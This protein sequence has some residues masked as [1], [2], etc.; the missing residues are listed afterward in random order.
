[1][2]PSSDAARLERLPPFAWL[3][4]VIVCLTVIY[5]VVQVLFVRP[6]LWPAGAGA[7]IAGDPAAHLPL[8][9][10][11]PDVRSEFGSS[12]V[13]AHVAPGSPAAAQG[14]TDGDRVLSVK[15]IGEYAPIR[16]GPLETGHERLAAWREFYRLSVSGTVE[17][18]IQTAN[19]PPKSVTLARPAIWNSD[20]TGWARRHLGMV[21]QTCVF[22]GAALLLL[23]MRSYDVTAGL[24]VLALAFSAVGGGGPL[25][26]AERSLGLPGTLLTLFSWLASPLAFPSI[27]LAIF[28]FPKRS[29]LLDRFPSL[30]AVP[31]LAALPLLGPALATALYIA[32]VNAA[33]P[34]AVWDATHP[35]LYFAA[36]ACALSINLLAVVEGSYRYRVNHN[37][38]E[39]RRIRMA[40]YTTVPGFLAYAV[41]DGIPIVAS[42]FGGD[43][44][45]YS[46][47]LTV[48]LDVLVLLPA[49]GLVYSVGVQ[50]VLGP[51]VVLRR[52]LQYALANR[53]LTVLTV[54]PALALTLSLVRERDRTLAQIA[55][56]SSALY[57][58]LIV[59]SVATFKYRERARL[60]LDQRF[61]REEYDARK[62]LLSL[63]SRVR[64]ETDPADLATMVI[65][66]LDEALHPLMSAILVS[67]IEDARLAPVTVL[68]GSAESLPLEGG[69]VSML[70]WSD[71]PLEIDLGD[72]RSP[73]RRL[74]PEEREWLECTGAV[75]LVPVVG[76]DRT[77]IAVIALGERR[78]EEAYTAE[79]RQL[80]A[81][82]AAQMGLGF[83]VARL[84]RRGGGP[85]DTD[86]TRIVTAVLE[87]MRECPN[88]GR[89]EEHSVRTCPND[90]TEMRTVPSVPR[91]IDNKYRI[92]QLLGRGGM[93]AVY[94][95]RDM[96]LDRLVALKVVRA[97]LLGDPEARR[98]FRREAQI[99]AR[100]QHPSIVA[101]FDYGT[102]AD[103]GAYLVM[104]LVR[105][106]DL[107][108][109]LQREGRLEVGEAQ[110]ILTAVCAAI[111]TAHREGVLHR[112]V[113]P[114]NIL[115]PGG[116][117]PPKVLDF[118]VAKI[119]EDERPEHP[120]DA[121]T[122]SH[123]VLTAAGMIIGTPAY[124]APEQFKGLAAD[125]RTDIF[126]LAVVAYEMLSGELP[127]GRGTLADVVLAQ[128][129]GV[130]PLP[131]N[132]ISQAAERAIRQ[133][134]DEDP[135]RRPA[136]A[137]A[138]AT[139]LG[140]ALDA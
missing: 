104:E 140:A 40:L 51:R 122:E 115:L 123:S 38:S 52:S 36:F 116:G 45:E 136:S 77:L 79:D 34:L 72:P 27:A 126:S 109:M 11:P 133:A 101:V 58:G 66:Q 50:H 91:T 128:A 90:G 130:P 120:E 26:G 82:I 4:I 62:I 138:F 139:L 114:E 41:R 127:F 12:P 16:F 89:C 25:L 118:G 124:M 30:H 65:N 95:A 86:A 14:I 125:P 76:R 108:H 43:G 24:C 68:H 23:L 49:F 63:A 60:W 3:V 119:V 64:F 111:G 67:G 5:T 117:G 42:L 105:G 8:K 84:R 74:P 97:E 69:L 53:S 22:T 132:L 78:S 15:R 2:T 20:V 134:L 6:Y 17:W 88:C 73:A 96:R 32:G 39:R 102:F 87:P 13:V 70:R 44:P 21:V 9:A 56:S 19:G 121:G 1:M 83:D 28:Y 129:R 106:E 55:T 94:R 61:F 99:V 110:R 85:G 33:L 131:P 48:V 18:T 112:D 113:K 93:G 80:L 107:R 7:S 81:S 59:A 47:T 29:P 31:I 98:R 137:Q 100:L 103:G 135:D 71:E 57:A 46:T 10:R 37:A 75:L 35:S 92:E 54:L